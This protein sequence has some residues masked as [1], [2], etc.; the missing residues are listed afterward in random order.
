LAIGLPASTGKPLPPH[1]A[2][3]GKAVEVFAVVHFFDEIS[4]RYGGKLLPSVAGISLALPILC[5]NQ[6]KIGIFKSWHT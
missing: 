4:C 1:F 5:V 2:V 6:R 3:T